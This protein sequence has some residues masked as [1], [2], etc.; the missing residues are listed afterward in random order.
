MPG[1]GPQG[2]VLGMFLFLVLINNAG[3]DE[4]D[5]NLGVQLTRPVNAKTNMKNIH[6][7]YVDD[8]TIAE[9][10]KLKNVLNVEN[11]LRWERPLKYHNRTEQTLN[12]EN[13]QV[14]AQLGELAAYANVNEMKINQ[15][16]SKVMLFNT[17]H[18]NDFSPELEIDGVVL[19][20]V[21]KMKLLGVIITSDLKWRENTEFITKKAFKRLWLIKRLKQLGASTAALVDLYYKH[22]RSVVEFSAVVWTSS[23]TQQDI[24][25]IERVQKAALAVI[26]GP[27]YQCYEEAFALLS[28]EKISSRREKLSLKFAKKSSMHPIHKHWL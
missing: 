16:K 1:G 5:R 27:R 13:S 20:L 9:A 21:E 12:P 10:L 14:Q 17:S 4:E 25:S 22:V 7:K 28:I 15:D 24:S 11:N 19:E 6:L 18:K 8:L 2:T 23:L 3:F 26:L